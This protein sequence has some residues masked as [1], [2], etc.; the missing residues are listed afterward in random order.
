MSKKLITFLVST[1]AVLMF[2]IFTLSNAIVLAEETDG[3]NQPLTTATQLCKDLKKSFLGDV[4]GVKAKAISQQVSK[5]DIQKMV[6]EIRAYKKLACDEAKAEADA[7]T[8]AVKICKDL[9]KTFLKDAKKTKAKAL[10]TSLS[11]KELQVELDQIRSAKKMACDEA[12][13]EEKAAKENSTAKIHTIY[14]INYGKDLPNYGAQKYFSTSGN[15]VTLGPV[16]NPMSKIGFPVKAGDT[17]RFQNFSKTPFWPASDDHPTHT[18]YPGTDNAKCGTG[19]VMF[20]SC[21]PI[22]F[23]K[24]WEFTFNEKGTW[25]FHDHLDPEVKGTIVVE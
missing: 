1:F 19:A 5:E 9:K 13:F 10:S 18:K 17:V 4:K 6:N 3:N 24:S 8:S 20:D 22:K 21:E 11:K 7:L 15:I 14:Y 23:F 12:K 16:E 2:T 25:E